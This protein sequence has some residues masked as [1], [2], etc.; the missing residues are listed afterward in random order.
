MTNT[1]QGPLVHLLTR[2][3]PYRLEIHHIDPGTATSRLLSTYELKGLEGIR[4]LHVFPDGQMLWSTSRQIHLVR[5]VLA[6]DGMRPEASLRPGRHH[7]APLEF[8]PS[9]SEAKDRA[10]WEDE[11]P[12]PTQEIVTI[13]LPEFAFLSRGD[14]RVQSGLDSRHRCT[15][16]VQH[17]PPDG[18]DKKRQN[19]RFFPGSLHNAHVEDA[20]LYWREG[21]NL[22]RLELGAFLDA[23][24]EAVRPRLAR[25][26]RKATLHFFGNGIALQKSDGLDVFR[27]KDLEWR[28]DPRLSFPVAE[29][30]EMIVLHQG[31]S[32]TST[33]LLQ[34]GIAYDLVHIDGTG[35][36][37]PSQGIEAHPG[38]LDLLAAQ[39]IGIHRACACKLDDGRL[40]LSEVSLWLPV[41]AVQE[42][43]IRLF[44]RIPEPDDPYRFVLDE[45]LDRIDSF[46]V[47]ELRLD[48]PFDGTLEGFRPEAEAGWLHWIRLTLSAGRPHR[49][50]TIRKEAPR[51]VPRPCRNP[52]KINDF[53][54]LPTDEVDAMGASNEGDPHG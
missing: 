24:R 19:R 31:P 42:E 26:P 6:W 17:V 36:I 9:R 29:P 3:K 43:R 54:A 48:I 5:N 21:R 4:D 12:C 39:G 44:G 41:R 27:L 38:A 11:L 1:A 33:L 53:L 20:A 47:R 16:E 7:T 50:E 34:G 32:R 8:L 51:W 37:D 49:V 15:L 23:D 28:E 46:T 13:E 10:L 35:W 18:N 30:R 52:P 22:L 25:L 45:R 40:R 2:G 14:W